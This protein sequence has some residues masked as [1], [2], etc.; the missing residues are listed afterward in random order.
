MGVAAERRVKAARPA[1]L[2]AIGDP[3]GT[4]GE[5]YWT[6]GG[7]ESDA[8]CFIGAARAHGKRGRHLVISAIEHSALRESAALLRASGLWEIGI[9]GVEPSGVT[10]PERFAGACRADTTVA[11]LMLVNNE[12]GT[13]QPVGE[14]VRACR[15]INPEMH[16][17]CDAVQA[18]GKV[19][20]DVVALGVSSIAFSAHKIHGPKGVGAVWI[21]KDACVAPFWGGGRQQGELRSGTLN[22]PGI[23][24]MG[25]AVVV[26]ERTREAS[27]ARFVGLGERLVERV[28]QSGLPFRHNGADAPRAPHIVSLAFRAPAEPLLH[29]LESRGVLVSAGSACAERE[30]RPSPVLAAI[31]LPAELGVV[32]LSFGRATPEAEVDAAAEILCDAVRPLA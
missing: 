10:T 8:L 11:A 6:S 7:T 29:V 14:V 27:M 31:D 23:A 9:G 19:P 25:E 5:I 18:L 20:I 13:I 26:A 32:R 22:V 1:L 28:R 2:A 16:V 15:A 17:H 12:I 24:A 3:D 30:R 21:A 4:L